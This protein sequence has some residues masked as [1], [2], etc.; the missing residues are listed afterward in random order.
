M[1][2]HVFVPLTFAYLLIK[3]FSHHDSVHDGNRH[4]IEREVHDV[5]ERNGDESFLRVQN[6]C[7]INENVSRKIAKSNLYKKV[8]GKK[9]NTKCN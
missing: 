4:D 6:I 3:E 1:Y 8:S 5:N 9:N 7:V 2:T